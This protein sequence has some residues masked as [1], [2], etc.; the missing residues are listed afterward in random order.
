MELGLLGFSG[1]K[2]YLKQCANKKD[3]QIMA[4]SKVLSANEQT[5]LLN[6]TLNLSHIDNHQ[7]LKDHQSEQ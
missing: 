5:Q 3:C 2:Y 1:Y 6:V 4:H 7:A